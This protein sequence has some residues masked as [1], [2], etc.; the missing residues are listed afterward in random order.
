MA[1]SGRFASALEY[2]RFLCVID[3][4][5]TLTAAQT[6]TIEAYLDIAATDLHAA[7]AATGACDCTFA[8]WANG[9]LGKLNIIDAAIYHRCPCARPDLTDELRRTYLDWIT[10]QIADIRAGRL[11]LCQ[12]ATASEFPAAGWGRQALTPWAQV[13][14]IYNYILETS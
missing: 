9:F 12:G 4:D 6:T 5:E 1:C 10:D 11:E 14:T 2:A 7:L 13:T 8:S 3:G